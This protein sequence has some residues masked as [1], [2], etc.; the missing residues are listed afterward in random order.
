[1]VSANQEMV[2]Y[3]FDTLLAHYNNDQIPP[4]AFDDGEQ[5]SVLIFVRSGICPT[6]TSD[7][8]QVTRRN[9]DVPV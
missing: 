4:P 6:T 7:G 8:G 3:C 9:S 2:V 5:K 1:M